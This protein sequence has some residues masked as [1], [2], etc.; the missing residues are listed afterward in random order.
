MKNIFWLLI[1]GVAGFKLTASFMNP[2]DGVT[3]LNS[4]I[5]VWAYRSIWLFAGCIAIYSLYRER[6]KLK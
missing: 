5:N 3:F 4:D 1:I 2:E 6:Q